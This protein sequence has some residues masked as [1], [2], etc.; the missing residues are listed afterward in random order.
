MAKSLHWRPKN[1]YDGVCRQQLAARKRGVFLP[2]LQE[3]WQKCE[4]S[5]IQKR[6]AFLCMDPCDKPRG[7]RMKPPEMLPVKP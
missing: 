1:V 7:Q 4:R 3:A 5:R 2:S 6:L